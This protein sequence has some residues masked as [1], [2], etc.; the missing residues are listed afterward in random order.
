MTLQEIYECF[1]RVGCVV[2]STRDGD[3][4]ESRIAHFFAWDDEG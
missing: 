4:I 1:D 2:F 3:G